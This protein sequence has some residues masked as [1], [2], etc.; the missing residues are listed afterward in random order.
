MDLINELP[1]FKNKTRSFFL[2]DAHE[3]KNDSINS[4]LLQ[5][6]EDNLKHFDT[7]R[8]I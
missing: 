8:K 7:V 6:Y 3:I 2:E 1:I 4:E 5:D